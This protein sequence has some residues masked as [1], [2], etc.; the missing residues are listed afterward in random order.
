ML[1]AMYAP[2]AVVPDL[3]GGADDRLGRLL[4]KHGPKLDAALDA[5]AAVRARLRRKPRS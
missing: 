5:V 1:E 4:A 2:G 3:A